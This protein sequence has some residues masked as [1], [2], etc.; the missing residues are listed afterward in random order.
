MAS[1]VT[2]TMNT[3]KPSTEGDS[4][5]ASAAANASTAKS[6]RVL[7]ETSDPKSTGFKA[8]PLG[9]DAELQDVELRNM[10]RDYENPLLKYHNYTYHFKLY[11]L[12]P[13]DFAV[14]LEKDTEGVPKTIIAESGVT[15]LYSI[16][17]VRMVGTSP[18]TPGLTSNHSMNTFEIQI[19]EQNGNHLY[20][21][22]VVMSNMLGY[23]KFCDLPIVLEL[24]FIGFD[25]VT[26]K[27]TVL[28]GYNRKW[29][30]IINNIVTT[31]DKSGGTMQHAIT[32]APISS[33][34]S[35]AMW[36]LKEPLEMTVSSFGQAINQ[37]SKKLN[38]MGEQ[39]LGYL[40]G[41]LPALST[42]K[43]YEFLMS[44]ELKSLMMQGS[45]GTAATVSQDPQGGGGVKKFSWKADTTIAQIVD[46]VLDACY[47]V[48]PKSGKGEA[49]LRVAVN[50]IPTS[51]YCGFD[52]IMQNT[53]WKYKIYIINY[54]IGDV[55][56]DRDLDEA[57]FNYQYFMENA[58]TI[59]DPTTNSLKLNAKTYY[60]QNSGLNTEVLDLDIKFDSQFNLAVARNPDGMRDP[61]N[62]AG[63]YTADANVSYG[64]K[65]YDISTSTG[66]TAMWS[67]KTK[68][69][70]KARDENRA[71][72]D[73]E[74]QFVRDGDNAPKPFTEEAPTQPNLS[75]VDPSGSN[76]YIEDYRSIYDL[77]QMGVQGVGNGNSTSQK[78]KT[79]TTV[80][81]ERANVGSDSSS[82]KNDSQDPS[83]QLRRMVKE[84]YYNRSFMMVC[85]MKVKGDPFWLGWGQYSLY[86]YLQQLAEGKT[87]S[88]QNN[89]VDFANF[90]TTESYFMLVLKPIVSISDSTGIID[91]TEPSIFAESLYRVNKVTH[92]FSDGKF[93]QTL[94]ASLVLRAVNSTDTTSGNTA[95]VSTSKGVAASQS[96]IKK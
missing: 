29:G 12:A 53:V 71:L 19:S 86:T 16:N 92:D 56:S 37:L 60:Y 54:K 28:D 76:S 40:R 62:S 61:S 48:Q 83:D 24:D 21:D 65:S 55:L 31:T 57:R 3:V 26:G 51:F 95:Q 25:E 90:V 69:E 30:L 81:Q 34:S 82:S 73:E 23:Q 17:G 58:E 49:P 38:E 59:T 64:D 4:T 93:N 46:D 2:E 36:V 63:E 68:I 22:L 47:P 67:A 66:Y 5:K 7:S 72:T 96:S 27:P 75:A 18:G 85:N 39:Q 84:N 35:D 15:G 77:T 14:F 32:A 79:K 8:A 91:Y 33:I 80:P 70:Q 10:I 42:G 88:Y 20:D 52:P 89:D 50:V 44:D 78:E 87:I 43:Y 13:D 9:S 11:S 1:K 45:G 94:E 74:Q 41:I 6:T